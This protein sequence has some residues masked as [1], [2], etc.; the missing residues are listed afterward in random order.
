MA[1]NNIS[2]VVGSITTSIEKLSN[3]GPYST[4]EATEAFRFK[5]RQLLKELA[6]LE[7]VH[8]SALKLRDRTVIHQA[9]GA[10]G[11][12]VGT[13]ERVFL[14]WDCTPCSTVSWREAE[15]YC[16]HCG[17]R[18]EETREVRE[19]QEV[20]VVAEPIR[21]ATKVECDLCKEVHWI[22]AGAEIH[23]HAEDGGRY[24]RPQAELD[25]EGFAA[26]VGPHWAHVLGALADSGANDRATLREELTGAA[27][28]TLINLQERLGS[29]LPAA[30]IGL[31]ARLGAVVAG[32]RHYVQGTALLA[33]G[34]LPTKQAEG[35]AAVFGGWEAKIIQIAG[36]M[37]SL[38]DHLFDGTID[39]TAAAW[40]RGIMVMI[41]YACLLH[42][43]GGN[44][45]DPIVGVLNGA[46]HGTDWEGFYLAVEA[47]ATWAEARH[48]VLP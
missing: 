13:H 29:R 1:S 23:Y 17:R 46:K 41:E 34:L 4:E 27:A 15:P 9:Q 33:G 26:A 22:A 19:I 24:R 18:M 45:E 36:A 35:S 2:D 28:F 25:A 8:G 16:F 37:P 38:V 42:S 40:A 12:F 11:V 14:R 48:L 47:A 21:K 31:K 3:G 39:R 10:A 30:M 44:E 6:D 20:Q 7:E 43:F 32:A 5:V